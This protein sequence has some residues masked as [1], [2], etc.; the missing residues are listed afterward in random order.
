MSDGLPVISIEDFSVELPSAIR[1]PRTVYRREQFTE[2]IADMVRRH[3]LAQRVAD[4]I[5]WYEL[6]I[7]SYRAYSPRLQ[8]RVERRV[9]GAVDDIVRMLGLEFVYD[10][11]EGEFRAPAELHVPW[12][13][14]RIPVWLGVGAASRRLTVLSITLR[15]RRRLRYPRRYY[16]TAHELLTAIHSD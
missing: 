9:D 3:R 7:G 15:T 8:S 13:W 11:T 14:P 2:H 1:R 4:A 10:A 12:A 16:A 6:N 5:R